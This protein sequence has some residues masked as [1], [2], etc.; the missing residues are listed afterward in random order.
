MSDTEFW[1]DHSEH[2][3]EEIFGNPSLRCL[4]KT[5]Q[6]SSV[7][8]M[9]ICQERFKVELPLAVCS[10]GHKSRFYSTQLCYN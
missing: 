4:T 3:K 8:I 1:Y 7:I 2:N 6:H 9:P 5:K 10:Q